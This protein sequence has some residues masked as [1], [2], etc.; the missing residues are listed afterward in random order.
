VSLTRATFRDSFSGALPRDRPARTFAK[1]EVLYEQ[2]GRDRTLFFLCQGLVKTGTITSSGR[3]IIY[4]L[5]CEGDVVGE[6]CIVDPVRRDRAIVLESGSAIVMSFDEAATIFT[7]CP[8]LMK[9][10]IEVYSRALSEAHDLI[11][12]LTVD[13]VVERLVQVLRTLVRKFGRPRGQF[14][15]IAMYLTQEELSQMVGARRERVSTGLN[16]LRQQGIAHYC[17]R[18]RL[19]LDADALEHY[20]DAGHT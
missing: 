16:R 20:V 7:E 17:A 6:L 19:L 2:G 1:G 8:T 11:D 15:E 3:E 9:G 12:R 14:M 5:R 13:S 18:G 4:D 10:L